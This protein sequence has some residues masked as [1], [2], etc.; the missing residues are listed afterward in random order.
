MKHLDVRLGW[1][2][3]FRKRGQINLLK[4][5]GPSNPVD[6]FTDFFTKIMAKTAFARA[7]KSSNGKLQLQHLHN[8]G[9]LPLI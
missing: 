8:G 6:F 9:K 5:P 2:Q 7:S 1:I 3:Q 4:V